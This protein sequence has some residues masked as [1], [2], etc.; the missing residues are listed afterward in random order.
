MKNKKV[1]LI[2][3][4]GCIEFNLVESLIPDNEVT[5]IDDRSAGSLNNY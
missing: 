2:G 1:V 5:V 3:G 4:L